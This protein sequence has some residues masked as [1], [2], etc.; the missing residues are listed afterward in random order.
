MVSITITT[1]GVIVAGGAV[2]LVFPDPSVCNKYPFV[3]LVDG[4]V[5]VVFPLL[6]LEYRV[7][8]YYLKN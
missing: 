5:K 8:V 3:P 7:V 1:F 4:N 2:Q 6:A